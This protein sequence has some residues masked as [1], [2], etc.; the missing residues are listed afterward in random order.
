MT[1]EEA[2]R[3][4]C[5]HKSKELER[6]FTVRIVNEIQPE[7]LYTYLESR[8]HRSKAVLSLKPWNN[9]RGYLNTFLSNACRK[10]MQ[11]KLGLGLV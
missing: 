9:R 7:E 11:E 2:V 6:Y 3:E 1:V 4:Y 10:N 5:D 8:H